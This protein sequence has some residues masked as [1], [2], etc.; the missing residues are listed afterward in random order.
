MGRMTAILS[1]VSL[2]I[3]VMATGALA[4]SPYAGCPV[5]PGAGGGSTIGVALLPEV[6]RRLGWKRMS[7]PTH[8]P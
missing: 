8:T 3:L 5:G 2:A 4:A 7:P 6:H 1:L